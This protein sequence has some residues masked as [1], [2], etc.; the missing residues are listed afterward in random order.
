MWRHKKKQLPEQIRR[1]TLMRIRDIVAFGHQSGATDKSPAART[2]SL[3]VVCLLE[4]GSAARR[5]GR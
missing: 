4:M 2:R 1:R 3:P 5:V